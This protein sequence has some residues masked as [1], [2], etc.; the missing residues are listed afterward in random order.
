MTDK[1][2]VAKATK[3]MHEF[4]EVAPDCG[5]SDF[6]E[7]ARGIFLGLEVILVDEED[8]END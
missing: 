5:S 7:F 1:E 4:W 2:R 8:D 6:A 3:L